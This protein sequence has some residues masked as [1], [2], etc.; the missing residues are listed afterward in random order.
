MFSLIYT[1]SFKSLIGMIFVVMKII[2]YL[3]KMHISDCFFFT[4]YNMYYK[5]PRILST[6]TVFIIDNKKYALSTKSTY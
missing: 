1:L 4:Y 5:S 3:A 2:F 6:T